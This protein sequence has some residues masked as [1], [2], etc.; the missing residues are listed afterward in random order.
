LSSKSKKFSSTLRQEFSFY[1]NDELL[2]TILKNI[3]DQGVVIS[4]FTIAKMDMGSVNFARIVVGPS[5]ANSSHA[6][7]V[8]RDV[9]HTAGVRFQ[10]E[11]VIQILAPTGTP[12]V[13]SSILQTLLHHVV[14]FATYSGANSIIL[15]VS[16]IQTALQLLRQNNIIS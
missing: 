1:A 8:T 6:N 5:G 3:A 12:G 9:L 7:M 14:V 4:A 15:N 16:N 13:L 11:E 2:N 10:Q